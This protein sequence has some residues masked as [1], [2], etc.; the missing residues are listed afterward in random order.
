MYIPR[1][2]C[3][4]KIILFGDKYPDTILK[5]INNPFWKDVAKACGIIQKK[6]NGECHNAYNIP[7]WFN[8]NINI[9]FRND[10]YKKGYTKLSDILDIENHLLSHIDMQNRGLEINFID[11][12]RLKYDIR[13][14]DMKEERSLMSGPYLPLLLFRIGHN[15]KG[16]ARTYNMM[17][18]FNQNIIIEI[19]GIWEEILNEE[20]PYYIIE[21]SFMQLHQMKEGSF[22][23][24]LQF[25][26]LHKRIVTNKKLYKMGL[27][28]NSN[29]PYCGIADETIEHAFI[30]CE[31]VRKFWNDIEYWLRTEVEGDVKIS[32]IEKIMGT[33]N[34]EC[35][36]DKTILAA[37]KIIYRNRQTGKQYSITELKSMLRSQMLTE[38]YQA[39][40]DGKDLG[41]LRTWEIIY[42]NIY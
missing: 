40:I 13:N 26:I 42:I 2:Y 16:C 18:N 12:A 15:M 10:W 38:E 31:T 30:L 32:N 22:T 27:S 21:N 3:I 6:L 33:G 37:K 4:H 1:H 17:M 34:L 14:I 20:I 11:Y 28:E 24:Y 25:R 35:I 5:K 36:K 8:S 23:K 39:S 29:C 19:Q 41:F 7:L 9:G